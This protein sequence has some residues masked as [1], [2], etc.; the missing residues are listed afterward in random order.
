MCPSTDASSRMP[1]P[2]S[3]PRNVRLRRNRRQ[4]RKTQTPPLRQRIAHPLHR[5]RRH[6]RSRAPAR[7]FIRLPRLH[8][9]RIRPAANRAPCILQTKRK[10]IRHRSTM[11]S[12]SPARNPPRHDA[13]ADR[14]MSR[15]AARNAIGDS[16]FWEESRRIALLQSGR[17]LPC[18]KQLL[19]PVSCRFLNGG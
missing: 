14:R 12:R 15:R 2:Q 19:P 7:P 8:S 1:A 18:R 5:P 9:A 11:H 6:L 10:I 16:S 13:K 17:S 4:A 3:A